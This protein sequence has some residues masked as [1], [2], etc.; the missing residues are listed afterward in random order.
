M[1]RKNL[2]KSTLIFTIA[3]AFPLL[4]GILLLPFY[5]E[6]LDE[7]LFGKFSLYFA[8][9]LFFQGII[10]FSTEQKTAVEAVEYSDNQDLK[11]LKISTNNIYGLR[12]AVFVFIGVGLVQLF[13]G[14]AIESALELQ[15][16]PFIWMSI[17]T[18]LFNA[19]FKQ[20]TYLLMYEQK[21]QQYFLANLFN[22]IAT[23][24]IS[25][26]GLYY[27]KNDLM[28]PLLGRFLSGV[29]IFLIAIFYMTKNIG[30]RFDSTE[31]KAI[32]KYSWPLIL[33]LLFTWLASYSDRFIIQHFLSLDQVGI[34]DFVLKCTV[35]IEVVLG[36]LATVI[37][38]KIFS[39]FKRRDELGEDVF[40]Y[41]VGQYFYG[42]MAITFAAILFTMVSIPILANWFI[43]KQL[44]IDALQYLPLLSAGFLYRILFYNYHAPLMYLKLTRL[45][46]LNLAM[47]AGIQIILSVPLIGFL[48][49]QG[50]V[51]AFILGKMISSLVFWLMMKKHYTVKVNVMQQIIYPTI[52]TVT[53]WVFLKFNLTDYK[54]VLVQCL[55]LLALTVLF[56]IKEIRNI[57]LY[58]I[59]VGKR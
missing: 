1:L 37:Y 52:A 50:A 35:G 9:T 39:L 56:F 49:I 20:Y 45:L 28:G 38:P 25:V 22:F 7:N 4:S 44:F 43:H 24:A 17:L 34:F 21:P 10:L 27:F 16:F 26:W 32:F 14:R 36:T 46:P 59:L 23:M 40:V 41:R 19:A 42:L 2:F 48:G 30:W 57:R 3:G 12:F 29:L 13:F 33:F 15:F 55:A 8:I 51:W 31:K 53:C 18:S 5:I 47:S 58:K 11:K 6:Y 54:W